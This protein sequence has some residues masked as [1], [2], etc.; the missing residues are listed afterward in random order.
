LLLIV[1][2]NNSS[3]S[4]RLRELGEEQNVKSILIDSVEDLNRDMFAGVNSIGISSGASAPE[5]LV[6]EIIK[7]LKEH[8]NLDEII[9][10]QT[11]KEMTKFPLPPELNSHL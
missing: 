7:W 6:L 2:S 5:H 3:N 8:F 10:E 11:V 1:G 9:E 4:N